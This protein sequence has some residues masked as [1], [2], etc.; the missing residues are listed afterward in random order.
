MA[1]GDYHP[2]TLSIEVR[3][4]RAGLGSLG[5]VLNSFARLFH[6]LAEAVG[7][8]AAHADDH[9]EGDE[10]ENESDAFNECVHNLSFGGLLVECVH[11]S[12]VSSGKNPAAKVSR[13]QGRF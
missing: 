7:G 10:E 9:E 2:R 1:S 5:A 4:S 13:P 3:L 6:I 11:T 12:F 8:L